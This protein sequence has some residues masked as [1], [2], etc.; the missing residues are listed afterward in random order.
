MSDTTS[1]VNPSLIAAARQLA[2]ALRVAGL[3][4]AEVVA[5]NTSSVVYEAADYEE[6]LNSEATNASAT[7]LDQEQID[8]TSDAD[9]KASISAPVSLNEPSCEGCQKRKLTCVTSSTTRKRCDN[10]V[11]YRKGCSFVPKRKAQNVEDG[12]T[13]NAT[14][15][16]KQRTETQLNIDA[17]FGGAN[18]ETSVGC[19]ERGNQ[20]KI[21]TESI[22]EHT[23]GHNTNVREMTTESVV[24]IA[25]PDRNTQPSA[26]RILV[27][28]VEVEELRR[29][30]TVFLDGLNAYK[31]GLGAK[32]GKAFRDLYVSAKTW[33]AQEDVCLR[34]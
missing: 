11:S 2:A 19:S 18:R 5:T 24:E 10:I 33:A 34:M 23:E 16:K 14:S 27:D 22:S 21:P 4:I 12:D 8:T 15:K 32:P 31:E 28:E 26:A 25:A 3:D 9:P 6:G 7:S 17:F 20:S 1:M 30:R 29:C 13:H